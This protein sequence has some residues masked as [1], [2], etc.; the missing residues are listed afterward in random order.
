MKIKEKEFC[1][2]LNEKDWYVRCDTEDLCKKLMVL[3]ER[4]GIVWNDTTLPTTFIPEEEFPLTIYL[5]VDRYGIVWDYEDS[6]EEC[7]KTV[8]NNSLNNITDLLNNVE[9]NNLYGIQILDSDEP[10]LVNSIWLV[11]EDKEVKPIAYK[12]EKEY[13]SY[14]D[15][16]QHI[17]QSRYLDVEEEVIEGGQ[18][19]NVNVLNRET[20]EDAV[21]NPDKY[22]Q[23]TIRVSGYAV[24][25]NSL[26]KEQQQDVINR[27]FTTKM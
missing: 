10:D 12:G 17:I 26:T 15:L 8:Y 21:Q 7:L 14:S 16:R 24:R 13:N 1:D 20:L 23:L 5:P 6:F 27:T 11:F 3:C 9:L 18:H 2:R 22:P 4:S 25:F 19:L